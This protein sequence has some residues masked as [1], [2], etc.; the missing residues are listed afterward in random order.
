MI[1][2][3][4]SSPIWNQEMLWCMDAAIAYSAQRVGAQ[5]DERTVLDLDQA[6]TLAERDMRL[7]TQ[8]AQI[9]LGLPDCYY[10]VPIEMLPTVERNNRR[11][12]AIRHELEGHVPEIEEWGA[13]NGYE[14]LPWRLF[15]R[16]WLG[17]KWVCATLHPWQ[18]PLSM[19]GVPLASIDTHVSFSWQLPTVQRYIISSDGNG[20][21]QFIRF[22]ETAIPFLEE[23]RWRISH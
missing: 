12:I 2:Y 13:S 5:L 23:D 19:Y 8:A 21:E 3:K 1:N 22:C 16:S 9:L 10:W 17:A 15:D 4:M 6:A 20:T 14:V 11:I 18:L 7:V